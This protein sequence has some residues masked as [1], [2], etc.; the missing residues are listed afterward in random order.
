MPADL[1]QQPDRPAPRDPARPAQGPA[2][3]ARRSQLVDLPSSRDAAP[4][5]QE[6]WAYLVP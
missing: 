3:P 1:A 6:E 4:I 2:Q 5:E